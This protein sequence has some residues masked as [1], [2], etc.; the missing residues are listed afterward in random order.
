MSDGHHTFD[1]LY[2]HRCLLF[3][4]LM[5]AYPQLAWRARRHD[6]GTIEE[7]WWVGGMNLPAGSI[8]YHIPDRFWTLLDNAEVKTHDRAPAWDGHTSADVLNRLDRWLRG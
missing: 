7:G 5:K 6:D 4:A 8:S 2:Q 1:E 3:I